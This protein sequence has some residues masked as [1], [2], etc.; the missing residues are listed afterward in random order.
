MRGL[1]LSW[2][3]TSKISNRKRIINAK[4]LKINILFNLLSYKCSR[5]VKVELSAVYVCGS[6]IK[7]TIYP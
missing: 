2:V 1:Y 4:E 3:L 7:F 5:N 6:V